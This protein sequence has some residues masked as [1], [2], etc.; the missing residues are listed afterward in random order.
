MTPGNFKNL[1]I[2]ILYFSNCGKKMKRKWKQQGR[3]RGNKMK[4]K[5]TEIYGGSE[6]CI[7][8]V[9]RVLLWF[10]TLVL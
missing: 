8:V 4:K 3:K 7:Y 5:N 10:L 6:V 9:V 2:Y 1:N